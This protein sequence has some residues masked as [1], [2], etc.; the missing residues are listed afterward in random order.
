MLNARADSAM[1]INVLLRVEQN[2]HVSGLAF[3]HVILVPW[4]S[5]HPEER[6]IR[7]G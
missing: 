7:S 5:V 4:R 2:N 1:H 6:A 3:M